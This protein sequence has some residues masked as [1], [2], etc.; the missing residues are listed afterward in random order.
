MILELRL[1]N[2]LVNAK[3]IL[4]RQKTSQ[5]SWHGVQTIYRVLRITN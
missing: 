5:N 3:K 1:S 4:N 2:I